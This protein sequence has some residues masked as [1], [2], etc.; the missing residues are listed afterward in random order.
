MFS[1][2]LG[3]RLVVVL[4]G[5][6]VIREALVRHADVFSD[7]PHLPFLQLMSSSRG[8]T[9]PSNRPPDVLATAYCWVA[10]LF[11]SLLNV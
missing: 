8:E 9:A 11:V 6:R 1:L 4:S 3:P 7:R 5:H 2:Y 10:G